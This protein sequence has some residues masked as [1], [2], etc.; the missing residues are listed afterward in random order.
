MTEQH[1]HGTYFQ[2]T[3]ARV[4]SKFHSD[5]SS[6]EKIDESFSTPRPL[7][8]NGGGGGLRRCAAT[9]DLTSIGDNVNYCARVSVEYMTG[10]PCFPFQQ[11]SWQPLSTSNYTEDVLVDNFETVNRFKKS[12]LTR[13]YPTSEGLEDEETWSSTTLFRRT[14]SRDTGL[15]LETLD[16]EQEAMYMYALKDG[17][18]IVL[19]VHETST[20][21]WVSKMYT[22]TKFLALTVTTLALAIGALAQD[23]DCTVT[24]NGK[25][26]DLRP[27]IKESG[28][29]WVPDTGNDNAIQYKLNV[30]HTVLYDQLDVKNPSDVASWGKR[31]KGRSLGQLSKTPFFRSENLLL[32][33]TKGDECLNTD[34]SI[35][36]STLIHFVCDTSVSGQGKPVLV[37]DNNECNFWFE[38]RTPSACATDKPK[39][40]N[41]GGVFGTM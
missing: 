36:R 4:D 34:G 14:Q 13:L 10:K 22:T 38:W 24:H 9:R 5:T 40:D 25:F 12:L 3:H 23:P 16:G 37:A 19:L 6:S 15:S 11:Q 31:G 41:S 2:S 20:K 33:Y 8:S 28:E 35:K 7:G 17:D 21:F 18:Q 29:D 32:E 30:C 1:T 26:Y 39:S 27:L